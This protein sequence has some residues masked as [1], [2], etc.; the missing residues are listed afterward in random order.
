MLNQPLITMMSNESLE[1]EEQTKLQKE[2]QSRSLICKSFLLGSSICFAL[3]VM[4]YAAYYTLLKMFGKDT[5][6]TPGSLLSLSSYCM[7]VLTSQLVL[8]LYIAMMLTFLYTTTK[9]G[10][11]YM[12][13][14]FDVTNPNSGSIWTSRMLYM[15][16][17][18]SLFAGSFSLWVIVD[19]C[20][21]SPLMPLMSLLMMTDLV[22]ALLL[23]A[24]WSDPIEP[25]LEDDNSCVV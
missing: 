4:A 5:T 7:L 15:V 14:K 18:F 23:T 2:R 12:R 13:K 9:S 22:F 8:A 19:L 3:Q 11:L 25:E 10:S 21:G 20:I 24:K 16:G 1:D 6:P 17:L